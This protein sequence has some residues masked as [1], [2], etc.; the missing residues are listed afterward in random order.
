MENYIFKGLL[1]PVFDLPQSINLL[2]RYPQLSQWPEFRLPTKH[3]K[4]IVIRYII[5]A[6]D[7]NGMRI[8][9]SNSLKRKKLSA[10][11]AGWNPEKNGEFRDEIKAIMNGDDDTINQMIVRYCKLQRGASYSV[12]VGMEEVFYGIL[13]KMIGKVEISTK[14]AQMFEEYEKKIEL[15]AIEFLNGDSSKGLREG[16][17]EI[18]ELEK[19][20][21]RPEDIAEKIKLNKDPLKI[22]PYG[23]GYEVGKRKVII[24]D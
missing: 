20:E 24:E 5:A 22:H 1:F 3:D 15:R 8:Y 13:L 6:Y 9:E 7:K 21:L 11:L 2:Q 14:E 4:N 19:L 10:E 16:L 23:E 12:L 18:I 17:F